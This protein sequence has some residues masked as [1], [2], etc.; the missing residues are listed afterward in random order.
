MDC[1]VVSKVD[2]Y[3]LTMNRN[4]DWTTGIQVYAMGMIYLKLL[5]P[6]GATIN[7]AEVLTH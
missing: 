1:S 5:S 6:Y 7:R 2:T 4:Q 3:R